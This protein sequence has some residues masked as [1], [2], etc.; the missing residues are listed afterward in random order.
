MEKWHVLAID[1]DYAF[2][3]RT[4]NSKVHGVRW[5]LTPLTNE[6][7]DRTRFR[8]FAWHEQFLS[9]DRVNNLKILPQVG[10]DIV[11]IFDRSGGIAD[12]QILDAAG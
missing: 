11:L 2:K 1:T 3:S 6:C 9:D 12:V 5:L 7:T 10:D 8:G 4:D